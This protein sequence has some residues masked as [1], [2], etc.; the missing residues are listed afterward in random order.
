MLFGDSY[1]SQSRVLKVTV[2][3]FSSSDANVTAKEGVHTVL[4]ALEAFKKHVILAKY[5]RP[6]ISLH[7]ELMNDSDSANIQ[8]KSGSVLGRPGT[9]SI[10]VSANHIVRI[11]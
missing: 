2:F 10:N 5:I 7:I 1:T 11:L 3:E 4:I 9:C 6:T 8:Y